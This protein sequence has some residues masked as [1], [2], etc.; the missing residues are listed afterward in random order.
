MRCD[1]TT[2]AKLETMLGEPRLKVYLRPCTA[3]DGLRFT[4]QEAIIV[5]TKPAGIR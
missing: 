5:A 1:A 3:E 2:I 4:L